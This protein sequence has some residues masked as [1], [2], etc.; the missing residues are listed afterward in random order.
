M[1]TI[2]Y[3]S[4][5]HIQLYMVVRPHTVSSRGR[6]TNHTT[7]LPPSSFIPPP[8]SLLPP[9][10][11]IPVFHG[12]MGSYSAISVACSQLEPRAA[13]T[14]S[15]RTNL[16][17]CHD[18]SPALRQ[19]VPPVVCR[20]APYR[21]QRHGHRLVPRDWGNEGD[22]AGGGEGEAVGHGTGPTV[23]P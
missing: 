7:L 18:R 12:S 11:S 15:I 9:P 22:G 4:G 21:R 19:R 13:R 1:G 2:I 20:E 6:W 10:S 14:R 23:P 8:S 3:G 5:H 16:V 17:P